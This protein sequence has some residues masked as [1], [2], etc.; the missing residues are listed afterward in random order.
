[1]PVSCLQFSV[2]TQFCERMSRLKV[3]LK[4]V[5]AEWVFSNLQF[6]KLDKDI[7]SFVKNLSMFCVFS[8]L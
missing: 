3:L 5:S 8:I 7:I 2:R 4:V 6:L 1:M